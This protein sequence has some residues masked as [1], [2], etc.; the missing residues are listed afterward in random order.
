MAVAYIRIS[1]ADPNLDTRFFSGIP[2]PVRS[3]EIL[4][5]MIYEAHVKPGWLIAPYFNMSRAHPAAYPI[6][7]IRADFPGSAMPRC[8][9]SQ[10]R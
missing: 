4:L 8:S 9:A 2:S 6:Q 10:A 3:S 5:E 7:T 1:T